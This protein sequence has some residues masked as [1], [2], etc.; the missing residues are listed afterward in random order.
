MF[1]AAVVPL[2]IAIQEAMSA[3]AS[4][5]VVAARL[6]MSMIFFAAALPAGSRRVS[7]RFAAVRTALVL[8]I[9]VGTLPLIVDG[10]SS[11]PWFWFLAGVPLY[12]ALFLHDRGTLAVT[13]A[14]SIASG[15]TA[16]SLQATPAGGETIIAWFV[17]VVTAIGFGAWGVM[18]HERRNAAEHAARRASALANEERGHS[19]R[20]ATVGRMVAGVAHEIN[21]PLAVVHANIA[22]LREDLASGTRTL[23]PD[24][25]RDLLSDTAVCAERIRRLVKDM[26]AFTRRDSPFAIS[27][28]DAAV[29]ATTRL[30]RAG[31]AAAVK[32]EVQSDGTKPQ[33][34]MEQTRLEQ[35]LL[36][37]YANATDAVRKSAS[38]SAIV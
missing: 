27:S 35:A 33:V 19:E 8:V 15:V 25:E 6:A 21:N 4:T 9:L 5:E 1:A 13:G 17:Q 34:A 38:I 20:L 28:I 2:S 12:A 7:V 24:E 32:I 26:Q 3:R 23:S 31:A 10:G 16:M 37:I 18:L 36:N 14:A 30:A 11:G 29:D 22:F